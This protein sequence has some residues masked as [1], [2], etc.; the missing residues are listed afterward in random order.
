MYA[1]D[2]LGDAVEATK[3]FLLPFR[4]R[5]WLRVAFATFFLGGVGLNFSS[6]SVTT[7]GGDLPAGQPPEGA[8]LVVGAMAAAVLLVALAFAA[9]RGVM[10][11]VLLEMLREEDVDLRRFW[12][13]RWRQGLRLFAFR[14]SVTVGAAVLVGIPVGLVALGADSSDGAGLLALGIVLLVPV[15]A[16]VPLGMALLKGFTT[17][18]VAPVMLLEGG[19]VLAAWRRF[20][21]T[22]TSGWTEFLGYAAVNFGLWL[23]GGVAL[24]VAVA[25]GALALAVPLVPVAGLGLVLQSAVEPAG[26][27]VFALA[28]ALYGVGV[29]VAAAFAKAPLMVFLRYYALFVLGDVDDDLD[30][31][32]L[33]RRDVRAAVE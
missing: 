3:A 29:V 9:V 27:A 8:W 16:V 18:F 17:V 2:D 19:G 12:S 7:G 13:A 22:L 14:L 32:P 24:S 26:L 31:V 23:A 10:D 30:L 11:L 21:P 1:T 15:L 4:F 33:V 25:V 28:G 6:A 20:W 5:R